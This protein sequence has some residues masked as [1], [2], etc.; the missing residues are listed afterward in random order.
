MGAGL[1]TQG[2]R[3]D[4]A[5]VVGKAL[6]DVPGVRAGKMFGFPAFFMGRKL[7]ACVYGDGVALKLP[8]ET[9]ARVLEL[10]GASRFEPY[11]KRMREWAH[12]A[13]ETAEEYN[14]DQ[15]LLLEAADYVGATAEAS[16]AS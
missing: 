11:G 2:H 10:P 8:P 3:P 7:F 4:V 1:P 5:E 9:L 12:I 16:E 15:E 14:Q 13:H 6:A